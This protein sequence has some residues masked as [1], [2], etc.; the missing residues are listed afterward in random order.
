M[1]YET[2]ELLFESKD[3]SRDPSGRDWQH[4]LQDGEADGRGVILG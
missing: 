2:F 1:P 3:F 4:P